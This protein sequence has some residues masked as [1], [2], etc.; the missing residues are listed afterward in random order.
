MSF[1][2]LKERQ[3]RKL[4]VVGKAN[5]D[6]SIAIRMQ[7]IGSGS[8]TSV[9]TTT[10]TDITTVTVVAGATVTTVFDFATYGTV[11]ALVDRINLV[12]EFEAKVL[13]SLRSKAT[14][15][16]FIDG[17]IT[18]GTFND[19]TVWDVLVDSDAADYIAYRL[20]YDRG[21]T[22]SCKTRHRVHLKE[23]KYLINLSGATASAVGVY[24]CSPDTYPKEEILKYSVA[25][26]DNTLTTI[27]W[28]GGKDQ[29]TVKE[30]HDILVIIP[31]SNDLTDTAAY[32]QVVGFIE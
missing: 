2:F 14:A 7:Y 3:L 24:D 9:T 1:N 8:V 6:A 13:D 32:A 26:V 12:G 15:S 22:K 18:A 30:G 4:G 20:C 31:D 10:L 25:T 23:I 19:V 28:R 29:L 21:F 27:R 11:G 5:I 17:A 16:Q